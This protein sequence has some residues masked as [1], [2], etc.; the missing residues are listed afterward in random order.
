MIQKLNIRNIAEEQMALAFSAQ[1]PNGVSNYL[2]VFPM[3]RQCIF[4]V[5]R[6]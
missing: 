6:T 3:A 2:A 4:N 5:L 1:T